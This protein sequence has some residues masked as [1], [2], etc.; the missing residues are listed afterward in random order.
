M[1]SQL[2]S[3]LLIMPSDVMSSESMIRAFR[4]GAG[5]GPTFVVVVVDVV[6]VVL[7]VVVV[8][9]AVPLPL[10]LPSET[11]V[12]GPGVVQRLSVPR[13]GSGAPDTGVQVEDDAV[14]RGHIAVVVSDVVVEPAV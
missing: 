7:V 11:V 13:Y 4:V 12:E 10:P 5:G 1:T 3:V 14:E 6:V 9:V 8:V 2:Q